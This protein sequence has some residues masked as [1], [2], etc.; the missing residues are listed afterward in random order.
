MQKRSIEYYQDF[1]RYWQY[2]ADKGLRTQDVAD[3]FKVGLRQANFIRRDC[4]HGEKFASR[5][6]D[7]GRRRVPDA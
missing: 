5:D 6:R 4:E 3:Q 7:R 2:A 1:T